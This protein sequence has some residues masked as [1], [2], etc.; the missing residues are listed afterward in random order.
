V[1]EDYDDT[2]Y[3]VFQANGSNSS[4]CL[5]ALHRSSRIISIEED[6][7]AFAFA[8]PIDAVSIRELEEEIPWGIQA[9]QADLLPPGDDDVTIWYD[10]SVVLFRRSACD[11]DMDSSHLSF[12]TNQ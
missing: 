5:D 1:I 11:D 2:D 3:T 4:E 7:P 6:H 12:E 10:V 9:I 8:P